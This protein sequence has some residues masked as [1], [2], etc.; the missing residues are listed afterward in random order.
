VSLFTLLGKI[1]SRIGIRIMDFFEVVIRN[2]RYKHFNPD[3][4]PLSS[5][6]IKQLMACAQLS[7][8]LS[9]IQNYTFIMVTDTKIKQQLVEV[10]TNNESIK[11]AAAIFA[12]V[13]LIDESDDVNIIDAIISSSQLMLAATSAHLAS[14][15]IVEFDQGII[16]QLLGVTDERL[17]TI[18][19]IPIGEAMDEGTQ[20]YKRS[21]SELLNHNKFG[22]QFDFE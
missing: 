11:N 3:Q 18:A 20:G 4:S 19:L 21:L 17:T 16:N 2:K 7:P 5:D 13:V 8:T 6:Q 9:D 22:Q 10:L 15:I 1:M 12:V 14:N